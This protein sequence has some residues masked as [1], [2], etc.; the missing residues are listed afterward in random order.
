MIRLFIL[1]FM[2]LVCLGVMKKLIVDYWTVGS[3]KILSREKLALLCLR[4]TNLSNQ[5]PSDFQRTTRGFNDVAQWKATEFR[6]FLLYI[7]MFVLKDILPE[8]HYKH[9]MLLSVTCRILSSKKFYKIYLPQAREYLRMFVKASMQ[10]NPYG[11]KFLVTNTHNLTHLA[12][13]VKNLD[14]PVMDYS[15]FP[16]GSALKKIKDLVE[17]GNKPLAQACE[18]VNSTENITGTE[19][20]TVHQF[21]GTSSTP[22]QADVQFTITGFETRMMSKLNSQDQ[23]LVVVEGKINILQEQVDDIATHLGNANPP[24]SLIGITTL[25]KKYGFDVPYTSIQLFHEFEETLEGDKF[26]DF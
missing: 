8:E 3:T 18:A 26:E 9:F 6:F 23:K 11:P 13:D 14:C 10:P 7:G 24:E 17:S 5:I 22:T 12:D 19:V 4:L 20:I 16:S 15:A 1:D 2:H 25:T 21:Q